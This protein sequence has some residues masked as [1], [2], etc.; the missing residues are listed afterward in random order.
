MGAVSDNHALLL[1]GHGQI[2]FVPDGRNA[3]AA[4]FTY[5]A[6]DQTSGTAGA[7]VDASANGGA[8][9]FSTA[10]DTASIT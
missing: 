5:R 9:A 8:T 4:S 7:K 6:W 3:D 2:R 10:T 1:A